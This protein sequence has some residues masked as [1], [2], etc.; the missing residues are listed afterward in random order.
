MLADSRSAFRSP[1]LSQYDKPK[2]S[3]QMLNRWLA[4]KDM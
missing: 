3:L 2:E 4:G 1:G